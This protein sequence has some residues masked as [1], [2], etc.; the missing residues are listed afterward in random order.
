MT[1]RVLQVRN[2]GIRLSPEFAVVIDR[3]DLEPGE[4][5]VFDSASGT[6]KSTAL[7]LIGAAIPGGGM[8]GESLRLCGRAVTG[9]AVDRAHCAPPDV[10]GFVLQTARLVPF[11]TLAENIALPMRLTGL[12]PDPDWS[13]HV[14]DRLGIADLLGRRPDQVSVGQRQRAAVARALW[15]RP[16]LLLL[17]EPVSALD[18]ANT[19]AVE[20]L[21][22][23]LAAAAGAAVLLAS[24]KAAEGAFG[25]A[26]RCRHRLVIDREGVQV[27]LFTG[28][29]AA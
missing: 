3:L 23:E 13:R 24:H 29:E 10:L 12:A 18:P 8:P 11:L 21:I 27:S 14:L 7:G 16:R 5:R 26:P 22:A 2:L 15:A 25:G 19:A 1:G 28:Q 6:G 9:G 17:D 4:V 20:A